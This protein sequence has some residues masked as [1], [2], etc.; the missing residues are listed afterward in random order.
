MYIITPTN[1]KR[2]FNKAIIVGYNS[3]HTKYLLEFP[4]SK[5]PDVPLTQH[6]WSVAGIETTFKVMVVPT[7]DEELFTI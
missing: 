3:R 4:E 7:L 5:M 2:K 1:V 6:D